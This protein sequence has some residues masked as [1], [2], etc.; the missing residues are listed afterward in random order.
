MTNLRTAAQQALEQVQEFKRRWWLVPAFGNK[1]NKA[2][3]EAITNAHSPIFELEHA[4]RAALEET[5]Q[6]P[7]ALPCPT[8]KACKAHCCSGHCVPRTN[9]LNHMTRIPPMLCITHRIPDCPKCMSTHTAPPQRPAQPVQE[10]WGAGMKP[11]EMVMTGVREYAE[12]KDVILSRNEQGRWLIE[13]TNEGG[14][15]G[16]AVDLLDL[17]QWLQATPLCAQQSRCRSLLRQTSDALECP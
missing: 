12:G 10:P 14:H 6:E 11:D 1:V 9:H 8:P 3:R 4:L 16:T 13:A 15:N 5:V 17:L 7:F 2:T